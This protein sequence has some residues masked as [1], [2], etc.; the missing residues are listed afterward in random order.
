MKKAL[1][2][3]LALVMVFALAACGGDKA[4][5]SAKPSQSQAAQPSPSSKPGEM[6][7]TN[8]GDGTKVE[9]SDRILKLPMVALLGN[10]D[11][12]FV[13][14]IDGQS[15]VW[16]VYEGLIKYDEKTGEVYP[17]VAKDWAFADDHSY[18]EFNINPEVTFHNGEK[19]TADDVV[20]SYDRF[21]EQKRFG[22]NIDV[23]S[24]WEKVDDDT[25]RFYLSGTSSNPLLYMS[26]ILIMNKANAEAAGDNAFMTPE[27]SIGTGPFY[28]T[29]LD[30]DG[31]MVA[32]A[33]EDYF[34]GK[35]DIGGIEWSYLTDASTAL[36]AFQTGDFDFAKL[37]TANV[38]EMEATG[39][40]NVLRAGSTH[41][42]FIGINYEKVPD[43]NVRQAILYAIDN[44]AVMQA[45]YDGLGI[46]SHNLAESGM[47]AGGYS[48]DDY[49]NYNPEKAKECLLAAGYTEADIKA[50]IPIGNI[51]AMST[52]YYSKV[53][54]IVQQML[55]QVGLKA[56]VTTFEQATVEDLWY[57][58]APGSEDMALVCHGDNIKIDTAH[59]FANY[60]NAREEGRDNWEKWGLAGSWQEVGKQAAA[61]F[62]ADKRND[63]WVDFWTQLKDQAIYYSLFHRDNTY[64]ATTDLNIVWG[65]N[66][67]HIYDWSWNK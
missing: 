1:S 18:I 44:N 12:A 31:K 53:A 24:S 10:V 52:N 54:A 42:S 16:Q 11:P 66:Y 34:R 25:V 4:D 67:Y 33:Y 47:I 55:A 23:F 32:M 65:V 13:S 38:K 63:L 28:F 64:I 58:R 2:L 50:G 43:V 14:S 35:A 62:D 45:A 39:K 5:D 41:N 3:I 7:Q 27:T 51:V 48:F 61:E 20:Y 22:R 56:E 21:K 9:D 8:Q 57:R 19:V 59:F 36:A 29:E 37:P 6:Q 49:Y 60:I 30:F 40:Y 17:R 15:L 46:V 26:E